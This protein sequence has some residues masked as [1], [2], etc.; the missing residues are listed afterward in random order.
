MWVAFTFF[1]TKPSK[2]YFIE[3]DDLDDCK[4]IL[5]KEYGMEGKVVHGKSDVFSYEKFSDLL[6]LFNIEED[7]FVTGKS[8]NGN[9]FYRRSKNTKTSNGE[10]CTLCRNFSPMSVSNQPDGSFV[11][12]SC[13]DSNRWRFR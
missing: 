12:W 9:L 4:S 6:E 3:G 8:V 11:C 2:L 13:R 7:V 1:E 5:K 10:F